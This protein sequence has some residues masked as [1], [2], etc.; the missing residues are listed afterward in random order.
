MIDL[1]MHSIFSDGSM[2]P[3]ELIA[4]GVKSGL[5]GM[6]LTDH[7]TVAGVARF[8]AAAEQAGMPAL[9]GVEVSA[10][11][12]TGTLHILGYGIDVQ[13][14]MLQEHLRWIRE[15]RDERNREILHKLNRM[16]IRIT[17]EEVSRYAGADVVGRPHI[18]Q[19]LIAGN[20]ARDKRDAFDR[21]LARGKPAYAERRR[22][23]SGSTLE[24]IRLAGGVPV[25]AHPF[26]LKRAPR[27][28]KQFFSDL[29][30]QGLGGIEVY[31]SEHTA[32]MQKA[33]AALAKELGLLMTGGSDYHGAMSPGIHM[34]KGTGSLNVPDAVYSA[35]AAAI[36]Q[37]K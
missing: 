31:Y 23:E 26:T 11:V 3:E 28:L 7:D 21:F 16:G 20:H 17:M 22:L 36:A 13:N 6:A 8:L 15:G 14:R 1:H 2:T 5:K 24:L 19:A 30:G 9:T 12:E 27:E 34:G 4:E 25:V 33:F 18:A 29:K 37:K 35:L 32:D 10:D